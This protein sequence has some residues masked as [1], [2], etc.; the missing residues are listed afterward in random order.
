[1]FSTRAS[2]STLSGIKTQTDKLTFDAS[3]YLQVNVKSTV[4]P[5]NLDVTLSTRA[6]ESTLSGL[7]GK[8]PSAVALG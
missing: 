8:F 1:L 6:S 2:E 3:N 5:S 4:N 7:S